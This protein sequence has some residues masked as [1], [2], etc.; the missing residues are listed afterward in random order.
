MIKLLASLLLLLPLTLFAG[1]EDH[2][3]ETPAQ[4]ALY[5]Q[6]TKELRCLVCQNQ[7]LADS[8][9]DLAKDLR[10]KAYEMVVAG[11]TRDQI[12]EYMITRYGD[13]VLYRPPVKK[14]TYFLWLGPFIFLLLAIWA[15]IS[16]LRKKAAQTDTPSEDELSQ[17]KQY[18]D[19]NTP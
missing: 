1:I 9:A 18:L 3:F 8:N 2:T 7:N 15:L 11:K 16:F 4:E 14:S 17:A 12:T 6:L 5:V 13:F 19:D 10:E